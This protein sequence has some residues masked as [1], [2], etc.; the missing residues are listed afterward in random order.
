MKIFVTVRTRNEADRIERFIMSYQWADKILVADGGSSDD[1]VPIAKSL[2]NVEVREFLDRVP[3]DDGK[4]WRNPHGAHINFLI[5]WATD[6]GA[7]WIIFD[8]CDCI[9]NYKIKEKGRFIFA[10]HDELCD[11]IMVNRVYFYKEES[12]FEK[13]TKPT[14]DWTPSL[15]AWRAN[16][17]IRA[18]EDSGWEHYV[19]IHLEGLEREDIMP[20]FCLLHYF[21]P[22]DE[23][24]Q[25]KLDFY[26]HMRPGIRD[27]KDYGGDLLP[28][29]DWM[30]E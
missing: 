11:Y 22:D 3:S 13:L 10:V 16:K 14:G 25:K 29:E 12:Y 24:M 1:T 19:D 20:P 18:K 23:F 30:R 2:P 26:R 9:P 15:W 28:L 5:D 4:V 17:D 6:E 21:Y 27:P 7:D 8:D